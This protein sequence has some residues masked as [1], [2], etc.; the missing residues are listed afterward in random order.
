MERPK[1]LPALAGKHIA[2]M[3][4]YISIEKTL[5]VIA[6]AAEWISITPTMFN[7]AMFVSAIT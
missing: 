6:A 3:G 1:K 7:F 5:R 2:F 4:I